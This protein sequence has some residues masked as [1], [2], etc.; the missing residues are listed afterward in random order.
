KD[1]T[2]QLD[3]AALPSTIILLKPNL[4]YGR[5]SE[6]EDIVSRI[7]ALPTSRHGDLGLGGIGKTTMSQQSCNISTLPAGLS[8]AVTGHHTIKQSPSSYST[9]SLEELARSRKV[10]QIG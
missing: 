4:F 8:L 3:R 1:G 10:H 5:E 7:L 6:V 2:T 9:G